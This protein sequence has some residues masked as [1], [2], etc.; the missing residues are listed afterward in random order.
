MVRTANIPYI[1]A[2]ATEL[3]SALADDTFWDAVA[4]A[5]VN[6]LPT[7]DLDATLIANAVSAIANMDDLGYPNSV[8]VVASFLNE[9]SVEALAQIASVAVY[10]PADC[11]GCT[12]SADELVCDLKASNGGWQQGGG[13]LYVEGEG[14]KMNPT[15]G[16]NIRAFILDSHSAPTLPEGALPTWI[17]ITLENVDTSLFQP[18]VRLSMLTGDAGNVNRSYAWCLAMSYTNGQ[19]VYHCDMTVL[20][21]DGRARTTTSFIN[22][23]FDP[24]NNQVNP[25]AGL[26]NLR[27]VEIRIHYTME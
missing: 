14:Y 17:E 15:G 3:T 2:I 5:L 27:L 13:M 19:T 16:S 20:S 10:I 18:T 26:L 4:C 24:W 8:A 12:P 9:Y 22:F 1:E 23:L 11:S 21:G 7:A 6:A 25:P